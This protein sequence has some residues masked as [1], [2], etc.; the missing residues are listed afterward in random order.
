[1][2]PKGSKTKAGAKA[3]PAQAAIVDETVPAFAAQH[4]VHLHE[5]LGRIRGQWPDIDK[6]APLTIA[7]GSAQAAFNDEDAKRAL[8]VGGAGRYRAGCN[9]LSHDILFSPTHRVPINKSQINEVRDYWLPLD[10]PPDVFAFD[11]VVAV[12][13]S[14]VTADAPPLSSKFGSLQRL[15]PEEPVHALLFAVADAIARPVDDAL[16][17]K[18]LQLMLKISFTFEVVAVGEDRFWRSMNLRE[19]QVEKGIIQS[20]SARQRVFD[21]A[22]Y[23]L[24]QERLKGMTLGA[25]KIARMYQM[26]VKYAR[27]QEPVSSS[28]VD[29]AVTTYNRLFTNECAAR[30]LEWCDENLFEKHPFSSVYAYQAIIDRAKTHGGIAWATE[31]LVDGLR[32]GYVDCGELTVCK[33]RDRK[34]SYIEVLMLKHAVK[35][36]ILRGWLDDLKFPQMCK[37]RIREVFASFD[38]VRSKLSPHPGAPEVDVTWLAMWPKSAQAA[39]ELLEDLIFRSGFDARYKDRL[40]VNAVHHMYVFLKY[41]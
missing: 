35:G 14:E 41:D 16:L 32:N 6:R 25:D 22:G 1:M 18:W 38:S 7:Q 31:G 28:F 24:E 37:E 23:K 12:D 36:E 19:E 30:V 27:G 26:N 20:R 2:P 33:L 21:V 4:Q 8:Q 5:A 40:P 9:L 10:N 13:A 29:V 11:V 39:V 15:S 34:R 17:Q 3:V